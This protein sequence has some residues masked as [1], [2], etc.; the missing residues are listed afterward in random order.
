M[1][2]SIAE[3]IVYGRPFDPVAD[4]TLVP[5]V[6]RSGT[7]LVGRILMAAIFIVSGI[8]KLTDPAGASGYMEGVGIGNAHTLV[9]VAGAAELAGGLALVF[10]FVTRIGAI[11][12][13]IY[14]AI[15]TYFFHNFWAL[16]APESKTQLVQ[17]MKNLSIIGGL[18][19]VA[20]MGPGRFSLDYA[21]RRP[22]LP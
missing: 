18:L 20:A 1:Q 13:I 8:A 19:M 10:G 21:M 12:L 5:V 9:Y 7:A 22:R 14:L 16:P 11:G 2:A 4:D 6:P 15:T 3:R 17:F